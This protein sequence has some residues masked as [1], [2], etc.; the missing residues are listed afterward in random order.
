MEGVCITLRVCCNCVSGR[1]ESLK[2]HTAIVVHK[3]APG[4]KLQWELNGMGTELDGIKMVWGWRG[5]KVEG[6]EIKY[7]AFENRM[8]A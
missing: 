5:C 3:C 2:S 4:Q 7:N 8:T 6:K 1:E